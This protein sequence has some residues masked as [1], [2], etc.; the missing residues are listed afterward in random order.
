VTCW[1][2]SVEVGFQQRA[3][4]VGLIHM[5]GRLYNATIGR[6]MQADLIGSSSKN[7]Q[8]YNRYSYLRNNPFNA[9]ERSLFL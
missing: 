9:K 8:N 3:K 5:N 7:L 2:S 4:E 6:F 1:N